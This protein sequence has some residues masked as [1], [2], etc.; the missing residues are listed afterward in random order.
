MKF[1]SFII[2]FYLLLNVCPLLTKYGEEEISTN[3]VIF[4][5]KDFKDDE[6]MHFKI[7][8]DK[9]YFDYNS[10]IVKSSIIYENEIFFKL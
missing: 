6:E 1:L 8:T 4:E 7:K 9:N 3:D 5:S 2:F 10:N